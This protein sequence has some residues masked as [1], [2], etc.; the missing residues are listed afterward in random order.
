MSE[1]KHYGVMGMRWG[2]R[3]YQNSDGTRTAKGKR[4][5]KKLKEA[6]LK[7][8]KAG[9]KLGGKAREAHLVRKKEKASQ[10]R[11]GVLKNK[12][13]FTT[14][15]LRDLEN[16]FKVEDELKNASR[17]QRMRIAQ[18]IGTYA[19]TVKNVGE[20]TQ[21]VFSTYNKYQDFIDSFK[22]SQKDV[23][24]QK[25]IERY[26]RTLTKKAPGRGKDKDKYVQDQLK[27]IRK[28]SKKKKGSSS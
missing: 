7:A 13:M 20:G 2:V 16:R 1:L 26:V 5:E 8:Y 23:R 21:K 17:N 9:K 4:H 12:K 19:N 28:M 25:D 15:E 22:E 3:N 27:A 18:E 6:V 10:T 11:A 14:Q 24:R